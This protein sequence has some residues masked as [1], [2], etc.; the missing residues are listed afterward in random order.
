MRDHGALTDE[1]VVRGGIGHILP[2]ALP[3]LIGRAGQPADVLVVP[4]RT[5]ADFLA[6]PPWGETTLSA[7][8]GVWSVATALAAG[9]ITLLAVTGRRASRG[10][11]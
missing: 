3:L 5:N 11:K 2:A 9:T 8:A 1:G 7:V 10:T 4:A 6:Q